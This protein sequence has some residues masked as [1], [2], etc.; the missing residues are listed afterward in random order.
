MKTAISIPD[1]LFKKGE[2]AAK[3]LK[4]S[5]SKLY[6]KALEDFL[7]RQ[8]QSWITEAANRVADRED[9]SLDP[10]MREAARR[11]MLRNEW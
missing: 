4:L 9:T 2:R 11:T 7:K 10:F 6:S 8:D 1:K 5:R 3:K